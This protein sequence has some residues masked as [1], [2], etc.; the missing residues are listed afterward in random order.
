MS[1]FITAQAAN[2]SLVY[3]YVQDE[4]RITNGYQHFNADTSGIPPDIEQVQIMASGI[5][6]SSSHNLVKLFPKVTGIGS[7]VGVIR[8]CE[9]ET[10]R[11]L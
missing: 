4:I 9:A 6:H 3:T 8:G 2:R 7:T 1:K 11:G 10:R 5:P